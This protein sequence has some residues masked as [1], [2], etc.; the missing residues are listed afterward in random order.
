MQKREIIIDLLGSDMGPEEMLEGARMV[1]EAFPQ[2]SVALAG[3]RALIEAA[4]LPEGRYDRD[5]VFR[6]LVRK[7]SD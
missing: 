6:S 5:A 4:G 7:G 1:L 3:P 2:T